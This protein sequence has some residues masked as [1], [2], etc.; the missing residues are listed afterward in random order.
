VERS[1]RDALQT[2]LA[3]VPAE[4]ALIDGQAE[5]PA[6]SHVHGDVEYVEL[7]Q[8]SGPWVCVDFADGQRFAIWKETGDI[9]RVGEDGAV[10]E[11][12]Y[13]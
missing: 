4:I 3:L 2:L 7:G 1:T 12:P 6:S 8:P 10:G 5:R 11:E 9:Y 13:A